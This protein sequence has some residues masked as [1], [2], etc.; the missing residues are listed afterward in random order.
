MT[1][2]IANAC[3]DVMDQSCI[4]VCPVDCIYVEV[5]DRMCYIEPN[6]CIDCGV[7]ESACPVGA[8]FDEPA[9]PKEAESFTAINALWFTDKDAART[10]IDAFMEAGA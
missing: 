6:E 5:G 7:C 4:E 8:I 10:Q 1:F 3:I 9:V 2:V